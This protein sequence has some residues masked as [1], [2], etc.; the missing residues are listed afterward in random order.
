MS[1]AE[2]VEYWNSKVGDTWARMQERLDRSFTPVTAALLALAAPRSGEHVLDIGCGSGEIALAVDAAVG[3]EG[4][5]LGLDISEQLLARARARAEELL[6]EAE[7]RNADAA[8][9]AEE[10]GF[11]LLVSRFGVMFFADPVAAFANLHARAASGGRLVFACW[12]P[13]A[14]NFWVALPVQLTADLL[15]PPAPADPHA[16]GP[17]AF[18]DPE[19]VAAILTAAGWQDVVFHDLPF[20]MV[21]GDGDDPVAA[22]VHFTM[23]IGPVARALRDAGPDAE[24]AAKARFAEAFAS[25]RDGDTVALP[26]KAWLV[27]ARA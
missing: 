21:I 14:D 17:F 2:Q 10:D 4:T 22:A 19:R 15:P 13:P 12:Q 6:S 27:T 26:A 25:Y 24:A 20:G 8:S 1:N 9:F 11:D 23:R 16:P 18:A 5:V 3:E 7:F